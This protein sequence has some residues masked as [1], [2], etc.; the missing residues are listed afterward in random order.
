M[1]VPTMRL[2]HAAPVTLT[3]FGMFVKNS[4]LRD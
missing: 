2:R 4:K 3:G 1:S